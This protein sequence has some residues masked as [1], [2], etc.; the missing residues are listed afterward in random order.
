[1]SETIIEFLSRRKII[2]NIQTDCV[3]GSNNGYAPAENYRSILRNTQFDLVSE[4][5]TNGVEFITKRTVFHTGGNGLEEVNCPNCDDNNIENDWG[6]PLDNWYSRIG[7]DNVK[8][9]NCGIENPITEFAFKPTWAFGSFGIT[10]WNWPQLSQNFVVELEKIV[11]T[12]LKIVN[13]RI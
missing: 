11:G 4:L 8:C 10:F 9:Q 13:E 1:M 12:E 7:S 5:K 6:T 3:L 2:K